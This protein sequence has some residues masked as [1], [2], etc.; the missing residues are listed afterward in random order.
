MSLV[1]EAEDSISVRTYF[2]SHL[3]NAVRPFKMLKKP[4]G[5][6]LQSSH[7]PNYIVNFVLNLFFLVVIK[8]PKMI[9]INIRVTEK[10]SHAA[11]YLFG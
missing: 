3:K 7:E 11:S 9:L 10:F 1:K 8:V 5:N 6:H 2:Y 4:L